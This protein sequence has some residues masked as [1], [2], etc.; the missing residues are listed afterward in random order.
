[1][2]PRDSPAEKAGLKSGDVILEFN[3]K[4][5][6]DSRHLKLGSGPHS[7]RRDGAGEDPARRHGQDPRSHGQE[8]CP[9]PR[10]SPRATNRATIPA[11][12]TV[13]A[14]AISTSTPAS[15][16][17][18]PRPSK[19]PSSPKWTPI[20]PPP[21]PALQARRCDPGN[22]SQAGQ[23]AEEAVRLTE[24]ATDKTTLLRSLARRR[25]PLR[26]RGRK[27]SGLIRCSDPQ[28]RPPAPTNVAAREGGCL[29]R[30]CL[31]V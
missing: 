11:R 27:Q 7:A 13:W 12:S 16:S 15:N 28:Y 21:K 10:A 24:N 14:S 9:A 19:A 17:T 23:D 4:K 6:T 18:C 29:F 8:N 20:P 31:I 5:V 25:Q 30:G 26:G 3:G 22:Q 2:S 1:M